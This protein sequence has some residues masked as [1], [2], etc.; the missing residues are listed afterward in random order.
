L[1]AR[2]GVLGKQDVVLHWAKILDLR[3][4]L[5]KDAGQ[6]VFVLSALVFASLPLKNTMRRFVLIISDQ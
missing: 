2:Q 6:F 1:I 4:E 3:S 5:N